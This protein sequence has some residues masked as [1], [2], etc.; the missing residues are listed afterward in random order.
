MLQLISR[1]RQGI[2][3]AAYGSSAAAAFLIA[4]GAYEHGVLSLGTAWVPM[5]AL[6]A[7]RMVTH[8]VYRLTTSRWRFVGTADVLRLVM[9]STV[10]TILFGIL[11]LTGVLDV[12]VPWPVVGLEWVLSI[13]LTSA[14]WIGYRLVFE[15]FRRGAEAESVEARS[16]VIIGAGEAGNL[17]ARE[18]ARTAPGLHLKGFL[19]DD[20]HKVGTYIQ[21]I[22]VIGQ[23]DDLDRVVADQG[24]QRV[25]VAIPSIGAPALR[26]IVDACE[27][28]EVEYQ[29]L[30]GIK[31]VLTGDVSV[32]QLRRVTIEDLLGREP[33]A[34]ELSALAR[35]FH[36]GVVLVTGAGGS[37]GSE[38][39]RQ[40]AANSP[41]RLILL[42]QAESD[43]YFVELEIARRYPDVD[44]RVVVADV[45]DERRVNDVIRDEGV[46]HLFHAAAYKH[47]PLMEE[48]VGEAVRNNVH[49]T[50]I[51]LDAAGT[52]GLRSFVLVSTDKAVRPSSVM[53]ATKRLCEVLL[54][55]AA[56]R[57]RATR[58]TAV[59]FG[60]V[61][62]S[63]GSVV[64]VFRRQLEE[65][66]L[67]VTHPDITRYFMT[68]GEAV[69]LVLLSST[70]P[71]ARGR[72]AMLEMG[73]PVRILD[74]ARNMIRL[75]G[76]AEGRD[77]RI[78]VSGLRPG[79]KLH[80]ELVAPFETTESSQDGRIHLVSTEAATAPVLSQVDELIRLARDGQ[81][82]RARTL[83]R[84][85]TDFEEPDPGL[86]KPGSVAPEGGVAQ[87]LRSASVLNGDSLTPR[88]QV[89]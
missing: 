62:G 19:D 58:Y 56:K 3:L 30:P 13:F 89:L 61:L 1:N 27:S 67:T 14:V 12:L 88:H 85:M 64:Q 77:V 80:E 15:H 45:C 24:V 53:G 16:A 6:V 35:E 42:D 70:L 86:S 28:T 84:S 31:E 9:S 21:G 52:H 79:E 74:L 73:E 17:L 5:A 75:S 59:R 65:G 7:I 11:N 50:R 48:N 46:T 39:A 83:L 57:H 43:L 60:N 4:L 44:L 32:R 49:G 68:V 76:L 55:S 66:V 8:R 2:A 40:V 63:N 20:P 41:R 51:L 33:V 82:D 71:E 37:I 29:V 87:P 34:V 47:V 25:I 72:I 38:L 22:R 78:R 36:D 10:G 69:Q 54:L 18:I 23:I 81:D 26:R